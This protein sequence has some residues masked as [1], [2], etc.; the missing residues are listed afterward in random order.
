MSKVLSLKRRSA[1]SDYL[2]IHDDA[3]APSHFSRLRRA[4]SAV[5]PERLRHTYQTTFWFDLDVPACWPEAV[6]LALHSYLPG[7]R[8]VVGVEW[9]LSRMR[10]TDVQV[11]F[12]QDRDERL[13]LRT[14]KLIHPR[15]S[16]VLFLNRTRGGLLAVTK[17]KPNDANDSKA[18]DVIDFDLVAP[19][20]N[21]FVVF[22]G[23]LTHGVLDANNQIPSGKL[24]GNPPLR[25]TLVLNWWHKRPEAVPTWRDTRFYRA[26]ALNEAPAVPE[27]KTSPGRRSVAAR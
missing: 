7:G 13:A 23:A 1:A 20:P 5:G 27:P 6:A 2:K 8:R 10:T 16:S 25:L 9:W 3:L 12:H 15:W 26:L 17:Q 22:D 4:V 18:P 11:D 14:G 21:R 19:K 24:P